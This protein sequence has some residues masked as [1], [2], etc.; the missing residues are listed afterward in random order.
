MM[1]AVNKIY[2][3][4]HKTHIQSEALTSFSHCG[5]RISSLAWWVDE[6][7]LKNV[8]RPVCKICLRVFELNL[9]KELNLVKKLR[10]N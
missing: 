1:G 3:T 10:E 5:R 6:Y 9:L 8:Q 7:H 4:P 2:L